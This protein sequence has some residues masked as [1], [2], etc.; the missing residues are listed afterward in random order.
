MP[1]ETIHMSNQPGELCF[2][3]KVGWTRDMYMQIGLED[4]EER[5][6][7]WIL[8]GND[9]KRTAIGEAIRKIVIPEKDSPLYNKPDLTDKEIC[10]AVLNLLDTVCYPNSSIWATPSRQKANELIRLLRKARDSAFG[11]DE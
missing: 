1:R 6:L 8:T 11:R 9:I 3:V 10:E 2:D 7:F 5:S 4:S